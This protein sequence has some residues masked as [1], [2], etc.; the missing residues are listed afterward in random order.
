MGADDITKQWGVQMC[1][2]LSKVLGDP[3]EC[4]YILHHVADLDPIV[5]R[6]SGRTSSLLEAAMFTNCTMPTKNTAYVVVILI[7][8]RRR[9]WICPH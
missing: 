3:T 9:A 8:G 2:Q 6:E 4:T 5:L 7:L 1:G